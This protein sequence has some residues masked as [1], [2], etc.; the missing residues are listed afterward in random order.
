MAI[1]TVDQLREHIS[2]GLGDDALQ[3]LL[4]AAEDDIVAFD[5]AVA[6]QTER[7]RS[8]GSDIVLLR[9]PV[10]SVTSVKEIDSY[11]NT[12]L[13]LES[14]DFRVTDLY[15]LERLQTGTNPRS[16]WYGVVEVVYVPVDDTDARKRDQIDLVK[17]AL[18][19]E[20]V[21][22][23]RVGEFSSTAGDYEAQRLAILNR[24]SGPRLPVIP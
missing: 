20:G 5:G 24:R 19:W 9:R 22:S 17:L 8:D 7:I 16:Y 21:E 11:G 4:D 1:L 15:L 14:D 12:Y 6:S 3:R 23:Q 10:S 2:S 18:A 13:T